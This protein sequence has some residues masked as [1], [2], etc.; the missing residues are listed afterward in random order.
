MYEKYKELCGGRTAIFI[1]HRLASTQFSD[2]IFY[3]KKG[4][5]ASF[6]TIDHYQTVIK[7]HLNTITLKGR[8]VVLDD[9]SIHLMLRFYEKDIEKSSE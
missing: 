2:R 5:I 4:I 8:F 1:S 3:M 6:F 7:S 9:I